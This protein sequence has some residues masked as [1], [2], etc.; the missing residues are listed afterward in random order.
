MRSLRSKE[1]CLE[2]D[3]RSSPGTAA[4]PEGTRY[5]SATA[6]CAHCNAI[7][8]L[9]PGRTRQ[10]GYCRRCDAYI[11]DACQAKECLPFDKVMDMEFLK[12]Y[13]KEQNG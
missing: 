12:I 6:T 13:R 3:H 4:V 10:R 2:I 11:C 1:G 5:E 7:V 9:N 8:V